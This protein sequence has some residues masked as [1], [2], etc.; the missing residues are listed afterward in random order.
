MVLLSGVGCKSIITGSAKRT[1]TNSNPN[2]EEYHGGFKIFHELCV[3]QCPH[4]FHKILHKC[5]KLKFKGIFC[6]MI[7]VIWGKL[8]N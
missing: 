3:I 8:P 6:F 1:N 2:K 4:F 7:C 5:G